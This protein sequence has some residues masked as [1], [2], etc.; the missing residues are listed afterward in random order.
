LPS[1]KEPK[2]Q[3]ET[4]PTTGPHSYRTMQQAAGI[5]AQGDEAAAYGATGGLY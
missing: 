1:V 4:L 2:I 5:A 3:T